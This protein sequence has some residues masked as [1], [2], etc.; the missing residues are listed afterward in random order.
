MANFLTTLEL[1]DRIKSLI[2]KDSAYAIAKY[3]DVSQ[4]SAQLWCSG[5]MGMDDE[6]AIKAAYYL[7]IDPEYVLASLA[8]ERATRQ[9]KPEM[10]E[11][12]QRIAHRLSHAALFLIT[13]TCVLIQTPSPVI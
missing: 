9:D 7:G 6:H 4:R 10:A 8:A 3:M 5:R 11:V 2:G 1:V 12:W 13:V